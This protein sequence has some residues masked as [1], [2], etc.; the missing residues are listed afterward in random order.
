VPKEIPTSLE[1]VEPLLTIHQLIDAVSRAAAPEEI[2]QGALDG[3]ERTLRADRSSVLLFD[4]D[5][6]MRFKAWRG[7][8]DGYRA[9]V[10]GHTPWT[11]DEK[12]PEPITIPDV[13]AQHDL[14][15]LR[16]VILGEGIRAMS[17][18]PLIN[19]G[20]L[21]GKFMIYYDAPHLFT[22]REVLLARI[23]AGHVALAL[24]RHLRERALRASQERFLKAFKAN[25]DAMSI[26]RLGDGRYVEV[27]DSFLRM[28][29]YSRADIIGRDVGSLKIMVDRQDIGKIAAML[30]ERGTVDKFEFRFRTKA[31]EVRAGL[32]SA[33]VIELEGEP[34]SLTVTSD[35]TERKR[36]EEHNAELLA[37]E[38]ASSAQSEAANRMKDEF[39]ATVSH[40][41]R[42]PLTAILGWANMLRRRELDPATAAHA[43][44]A[45]ERNARSQAQIIDDILDVSRIITG[46]LRLSVRPIDALTVVHEAIDAVRPAAEAKGIKI[47]TAMEAGACTFM[48]DPNRMQ[49]VIWNLLANAI[50]FTAHGGGVEVRLARPGS[51][52][53]IAVSDT[54]Q[55]ISAEFLPYVFDRFRQADSSYQRKHGGLGLGLSIV[56]HIVEM[57]GGT[58]QARSAGEGA[59]ATFVLRIPLAAAG[60]SSFHA[61]EAPE[62]AE[63]A[64]PTPAS[65]SREAALA[66]FKVLLVDDEPDTLHMLKLLLEQSGATVEACGSAAEALRA[67]RE[68]EPDVLISDIGMPGEDGYAL[69][70]KIRALELER[71]GRLPAIALTAYAAAEDRSQALAAGYQRH[72]TKPVDPDDLVAV[73]AALLGRAANA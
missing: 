43:F 38:Q 16:Q 64:R 60:R 40:E 13:E 47:L 68:R 51:H 71:G 36:V 15:P 4:V 56:R 14:G 19:Q 28:T 66:G 21:L 24:G 1:S 23:V 62:P 65:A 53:E 55:G 48:G 7:L 39:L 58:V 67:A 72:V 26:R 37:R 22:G 17:F 41:L 69:I 61:G 11:R 12:D 32:L 42:T 6:V 34:H 45:I 20:A 52:V 33:E 9:R 27:N 29:G 18:I 44:E 63:T 57:H 46:K 2:Y 25:P 50:K 31:G 5:G 3:L 70:N 59:G 8:S 35:I 30:E 73:V 10:E 54:G 49:Q